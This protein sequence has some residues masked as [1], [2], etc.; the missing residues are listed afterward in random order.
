M[1]I[2]LKC[3]TIDVWGILKFLTKNQGKPLQILSIMVLSLNGLKADRTFNRPYIPYSMKKRKLLYYY[4]ATAFFF[5]S[6]NVKNIFP[7]ILKE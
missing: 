5:V 1:T 4:G 6:Y 3:Q 7:I 2:I